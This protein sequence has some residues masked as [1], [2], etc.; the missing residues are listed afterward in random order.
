MKIKKLLAALLAAFVLVASLP[1][2]AFATTPSGD[3][4]CYLV[5]FDSSQWTLKNTKDSVHID[6]DGNVVSSSNNTV[7]VVY[8]GSA[9][10]LS[11]GFVLQFSTC[12]QG[13]YEYSWGNVS[14]LT[15]GGIYFR[16]ANMSGTSQPVRY[17]IEYNNT[18]A[19]FSSKAYM[20]NGS[21]APSESLAYVDTLFTVKYVDGKLSFYN[22]G[23]ISETNPEGVI[24]WTLK[25]GTKA[26]SIEYDASNFKETRI[27]IHKDWGGPNTSHTILSDLYLCDYE[28]FSKPK[29]VLSKEQQVNIA[30]IG[31]SIT[32]GVGTYSGY[33]YY[34]FEDLYNAGCKFHFVGP[35]DSTDPRLP[36][37]YSRHGGYS[38]AVIGPNKNSGARSSYDWLDAYI[39]GDAGMADIALVMLGHNNY[40]QKIDTYN[41]DEVYKNFVRKI[42]TI[43]PD[44]IVYCATIVNDTT[45]QS[46]D[47]GKGFVDNGINALMPTIVSDLQ[48]EGYDVRFVDLRAITNLSG[49]NG[50]FSGSDGVH[51][52]EQGQ[53]KIGDAWYDAVVDRV[54]EMNA[55]G[56]GS[57]EATIKPVTDLSIDK[58]EMTLTVGGYLKRINATV[59]LAGATVPTVLWTSSDESVATVNVSGVVT[60][61][62]EGNAVITAKTLDG[63]L[64]K[65][66]NVTV[67]PQESDTDGLSE[68]FYDTYTQ[69]DRYTGNAELGDS[70]LYLYFP[71]Q[72]I[73]TFET[74]RHFKTD[75]EFKLSARYECT[76]NE[77]T[78]N[79]SYTG[80]SF[81]GLQMRVYD[82]GKTVEL[83]LGD[84][85]L[86]K[87]STGFEVGAH[88]Y[89]LYYC[90]GTAYIVRDNE[91]IISAAVSRDELDDS[92]PIAVYSCEGNR[93]AVLYNLRLTVKNPESPYIEKSV[94]DTHPKNEFKSVIDSFDSN[95]WT[96][97]GPD[98]ATASISDNAIKCSSTGELFADYTG[99]KVDLSKGFELN[100]TTNLAANS[101][102][103]RSAY[104]SVGSFAL[105]IRTAFDYKQK[106]GCPLS[107]YAY[108]NAVFD[109]TTGAMTSGDIVG[110][111]YSTASGT[112]NINSPEVDAFLNDTYT[113][114][115]DGTNM[116]VKSANHGTLKFE[117][118]DGSYSAAIPVSADQLS[119]S[120]LHLYKES[121]GPTSGATEGFFSSLS[122]IARDSSAV[123]PDPV[124]GDLN[125]DD[126]VDSEDMLI[127]SQYILGLTDIEDASLLDM[128]GNGS[129]DAADLLIMQMII[130]GA[131]DS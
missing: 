120:G 89:V 86:G 68:I 28:Y 22:K 128:D 119:A 71:G 114:Y 39:N 65:S 13:D 93:F 112:V 32:Y 121:M 48:T 100:V 6:N 17:S 40:Y 118:I 31:D 37:A 76:G 60:P 95:S 101:F 33:R 36:G 131:I 38:G 88:E 69:Y 74:I 73:T 116:Y 8:S 110:M 66:C 54:K 57:Y 108:T 99:S 21:P 18:S 130:L 41:I 3:P 104:I 72:K 9:L 109:E 59:Q 34:L 16:I 47:V 30:C 61:V 91:I 7:D 122:L 1:V 103:G 2:A 52:N 27:S 98:D 96:V 20:N 111:M 50:D 80:W 43:N 56:D 113:L 25:N 125:G 10:D 106:G 127:L 97:K 75:S 12:L 11:D 123:I 49:A 129:V 78:Y 35:Y 4:E 62:S 42:F 83:R 24:E 87:W 81:G 92:T 77:T 107:I 58:T 45:G 126:K 55:A 79:G 51:P 19:S 105:R 85:S 67:L 117:L 63:G 70:A 124:I 15:M 46:P 90:N 64:T 23:M 26:T 94:V 84:T 102:W 5:G 82:A 53:K 29:P 14:Y 115:Y 44:I